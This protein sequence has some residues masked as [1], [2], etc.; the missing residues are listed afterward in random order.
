MAA[1]LIFVFSLSALTLFLFQPMT[2]NIVY[3]DELVIKLYFMFFLL[4]LFPE[5]KKKRKKK[6]K[7]RLSIIKR[8]KSG[9]NALRHIVKSSRLKINSLLPPIGTS[10]AAPALDASFDI[11]LFNLIYSMLISKS[12]ISE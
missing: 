9:K 7:K 8:L 11:S 1:L 10:E 4:C 3:G 6:R 5:R 2:V 12:V